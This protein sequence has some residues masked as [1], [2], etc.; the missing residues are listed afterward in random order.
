MGMIYQAR[1]NAYVRH[2][3]EV[4]QNRY[5][6]PIYELL[7]TGVKFGLFGKIF[8]MS[9]GNIPIIPKSKWSAIE[10]PTAWQLDDTYWKSTAIMHNKNDL[11][12]KTMGKAQ[13]LTW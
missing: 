2:T 8:E 4:K 1:F 6:S 3:E 10:W 9:N 12:T 7:N 5:N 13:Y 11:L